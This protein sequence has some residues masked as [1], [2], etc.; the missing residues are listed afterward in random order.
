LENEEVGT[1][2]EQNAFLEF[3]RKALLFL[4]NFLFPRL[5]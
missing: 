2:P 3:F 1:L 4:S 5:L